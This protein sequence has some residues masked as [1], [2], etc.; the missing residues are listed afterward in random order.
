ME[1]NLTEDECV[2]NGGHCFDATGQ[3][4]DGTPPQYP[5]ACRHC[6]KR[7]IG[8]PQAAMSYVDA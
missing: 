8:T 1:T 5:E 7:R 3:V 2:A 4:I 6:C